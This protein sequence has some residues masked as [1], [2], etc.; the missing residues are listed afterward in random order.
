MSATFLIDFARDL[1]PRFYWS[2]PFIAIA[3]SGIALGLLL[4]VVTKWTPWLIASLTAILYLLP[5]ML[6]FKV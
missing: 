3:M 5:F 4:Y 6:G 1:F 2:A